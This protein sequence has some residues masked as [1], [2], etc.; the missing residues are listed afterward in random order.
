MKQEKSP[1]ANSQI[2]QIQM[3][4]TKSRSSN[5][6]AY[7]CGMG[8]VGEPVLCPF[9]ASPALFRI[10][11]PINFAVPGEIRC[12]VARFRCLFCYFAVLPV[13]PLTI[14]RQ[15]ATA[16]FWLKLHRFADWAFLGVAHFS[17]STHRTPKGLTV[18]KSAYAEDGKRSTRGARKQHDTLGLAG[19]KRAETRST[20]EQQTK[21]KPAK[22][23][24]LCGES[25]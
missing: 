1:Q 18:G 24:C 20:N 12:S 5:R 23:D 19:M 10:F 7:A 15:L 6:P 4:G 16:C 2:G 21:K 17:A 14:S 8:C 13:L 3:S 22:Q 25:T 11:E 9:L